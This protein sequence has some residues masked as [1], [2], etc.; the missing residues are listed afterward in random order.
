MTGNGCMSVSWQRWICQLDDGHV[1]SPLFLWFGIRVIWAEDLCHIGA[2]RDWNPSLLT[3]LSKA[4]DSAGQFQCRIFKKRLED[5]WCAG[6]RE[7]SGFC[8]AVELSFHHTTLRLWSIQ[9]ICDEH[10]CEFGKSSFL[11]CVS[12]RCGFCSQNNQVLDLKVYGARKYFSWLIFLRKA[13]VK[14]TNVPAMIS[15]RVWCGQRCP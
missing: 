13:P 3:L 1:W 12:F 9:K 14:W 8:S 5:R 10:I 15:C 6:H 2:D 4:A 11:M 7:W